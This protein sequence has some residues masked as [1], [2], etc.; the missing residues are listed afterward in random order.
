[1]TQTPPAPSLSTARSSTSPASD[2]SAATLAAAMMGFF[3]IALDA[4]VVT[5]ALPAI[6]SSVSGG[7]SGLQW[8]V[9]GYTLMF[10]ALML[11]AGALSDRIGA[12]RAFGLGLALFTLASLACGLAP[13]L[14]LLIGARLVQGAAASLMMP[15]SLALV[16]QAFP[17]A[18]RRVRAITIWTGAGAVAA[19][20]GPVAGGALTSA[21]GW[22]SIFFLNIPVGLVGLVLLRRA[23]RSERRPAPVD[24]PG[25]LT[26]VVALAALTFGVIQGGAHGFGNTAALVSLAVAVVSAT[27]FLAVEATTKQPMMPLTLFR[28]RTMSVTTAAGFSINVAFY[29]SIFVLSLFFQQAHGLSA[30]TA[31]L[32]FLPMTALVAF[33][34]L[35]VAAKVIK[36]FGPRLPIALGQAGTAASLLGLLALGNHTPAPLMALAVLPVAFAGSLSVPSLTAMLMGHVPAERAGSAAGVLNTARQVG[37]ALAIAVFG[38][39][40]ADKATFAHGMHTALVIS[41]VLLAITATASALLLPKPAAKA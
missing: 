11:S 16:R 34:N 7:M 18:E 29:G 32:M 26:G 12:S 19:A 8:V 23:P 2:G 6:S 36:R 39:L 41:A 22:R 15:A 38:A 24:L 3:I 10:A 17:D 9:D 21:L 4:L 30:I 28:S 33:M 27:A 14:G 20:A 5:V 1:M 37:G 31:G 13:N 40:V 35:F 25:Q